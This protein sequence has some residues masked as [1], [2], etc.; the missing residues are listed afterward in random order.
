MENIWNENDYNNPYIYHSRMSK[1]ENNISGMHHNQAN[2]NEPYVE[3]VKNARLARAYVPY[4][5]W[6]NTYTPCECLK[7][8][9]AFPELYSPYEY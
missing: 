5:V 6:S 9:T 1:S 2:Q 7:K 8:G 3:N 4:Q